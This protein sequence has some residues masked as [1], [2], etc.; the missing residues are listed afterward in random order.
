MKRVLFILCLIIFQSVGFCETEENLVEQSNVK[1]YSENGLFG[2]NTTDGKNITET[3][4]QKLIR[5]GNNGIFLAQR[6]GKFGLINSEGNCIVPI[7]NTQAERVF[8]KYVKLKNIHGWGLFDDNGITIIPQQY[9]S[10][11]PLF[12]KMFL[13]K[14]NYKYG[15]IN[16]EGKKLL[17]NDFEDIYMPNP[18]TLRIKYNGEWYEIIKHEGENFALDDNTEVFYFEDAVATFS[19]F[20]EAPKTIKL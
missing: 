15:I 1:I 6:K 14:R 12:G 9:S 16:Y 20:T 13:T 17:N 18:Q 10:I 19:S 11:D 2:L 3:Q 4:N 5:I 7:R 8:S